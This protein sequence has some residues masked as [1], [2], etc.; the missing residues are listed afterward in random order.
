MAANALV[1]GVA[2]SSAA[3]VQNALDE[4]VI[5]QLERSQQAVASRSGERIENANI[6]L[7]VP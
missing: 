3:M 2:R 7:Y 1:T 5:A 6:Y 4:R